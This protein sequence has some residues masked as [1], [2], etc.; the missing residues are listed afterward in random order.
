MKRDKR[1]V[2]ERRRRWKKLEYVV[3]YNQDT[4][5]ADLKVSNKVLWQ[6]LYGGTPPSNAHLTALEEW[7][8]N[9]SETE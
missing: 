5:R 7:Q 6:W 3:L 2:Q 8:E 1:D 4:I 9:H